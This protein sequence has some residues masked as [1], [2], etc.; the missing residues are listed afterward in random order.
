VK[1]S[2]LKSL[3]REALEEMSQ[4]KLE[5]IDIIKGEV[6]Q[7][8]DGAVKDDSMTIRCASG[9]SYEIQT[10]PDE[11]ASAWISEINLDKLIGKK[12]V[13]AYH[14]GKDCFG[15]TLIMK[16]ED[17]N[18][19][20][21]TIEADHNGYY[22]FSYQVTKS[23]AT[24]QPLKEEAVKNL[25]VSELMKRLLMAIGAEFKNSSESVAAR[26]T[27]LLVMKELVKGNW[28]PTAKTQTETKK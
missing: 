6:I 22:G 12:I 18:V 20:H 28:Q 7:S 14:D 2:E 25:E 27:L 3:I 24:N 1:R 5:D 4:N 19:G 17:G 21:V 15:V 13:E 9:N 16:A 11:Y 26:R 10:W 23:Q 8:F